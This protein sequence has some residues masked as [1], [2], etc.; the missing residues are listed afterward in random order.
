MS[1]KAHIK[2][3]QHYYLDWVKDYGPTPIETFMAA[4]DVSYT[5]AYHKL[6]GLVAQGKLKFN[7][8]TKE[9]EHGEQDDH[10]NS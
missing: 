1:R 10:R 7:P 5:T 8:T 3:E 6:R 9:Y 4:F 2:V